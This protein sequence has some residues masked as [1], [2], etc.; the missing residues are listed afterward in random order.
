MKIFL[1]ANIIVD[2]LDETSYDNTL[3]LEVLRLVRL[4]DTTIY[5]SPTTFAITFYIFT[6]RN[7]TKS[8]VR[9]ILV[10]F[11]REFNFT[12]ESQSIM[13]QVLT[14]DFT[15]L[16]DALQYFSVKDAGIKVIITKN[17]KDFKET[18]TVKIFHPEEFVYSY[19]NQ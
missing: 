6:K 16:E 1:D 10:E 17:K 7:K 2:I 3:A 4:S 18:G 8:N 19:Y 14:S 13:K 11:F 15:D 9:K 12:T 5:I